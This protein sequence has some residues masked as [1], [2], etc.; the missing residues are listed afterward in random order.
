MFSFSFYF[1]GDFRLDSL[2][3]RDERIMVV[4]DPQ[5]DV[6][7]AN[8]AGCAEILCFIQTFLHI[9]ILVDRKSVV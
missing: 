2:Y 7:Y 9:V 5:L 3:L 4:D 1:F 6:T 8:S